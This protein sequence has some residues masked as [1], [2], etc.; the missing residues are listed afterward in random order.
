M[1]ANFFERLIGER[2]NLRATPL[3]IENA[4]AAARFVLTVDE[5]AFAD[6]IAGRE[7]AEYECER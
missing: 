1:M 7:Q 5:E 2:G 6:E 3:D 4:R